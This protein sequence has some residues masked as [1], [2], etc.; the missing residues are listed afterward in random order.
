MSAIIFG[1]DVKEVTERLEALAEMHKGKTV[2]D[3]AEMFDRMTD[4]EKERYIKVITAE[5]QQFK[6][7]ARA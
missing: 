6:E 3:L 2:S 1:G 7:I 4:E 5:Y